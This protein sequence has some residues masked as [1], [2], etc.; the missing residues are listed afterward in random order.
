MLLRRLSKK[1]REQD[2][3]ATGTELVIVA[4]GVFMGLQAQNWN[5]A[6][7]ER[8]AADDYR[9]RLV[10]ELRRNQH[11]LEARR[12]YYT[13]V[14]DR[15]Q[16]VLDALDGPA[17]DLDVAFI[18]DAY[19]A[20]QRWRLEV[21]RGVY[22]EVMNAGAIGAT[23]SVDSRRRV[24]N[25][26]NIFDSVKLTITDDPGYRNLVRAHLP[27]SMQRKIEAGCGDVVTTDADG[28]I[29]I[30]LPDCAP[31]WKPSATRA[32][33]DALLDAPDFRTNLNFRLSSVETKLTV[34][35]RNIDRCRGLVE[36]LERED[37][38]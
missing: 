12:D 20:S 31:D 2:W 22:D 9:T 36:H 15:A 10:E 32:G 26:F 4:I 14:Q 16:A 27:I 13:E 33:I 35:G 37:V 1:L 8:R 29:S 28:A 18:V 24:T 21:D 38:G 3:A 11:N 30:T 7:Q 34:L 6:R 23:L 19:M 5:E 25:L 17:D